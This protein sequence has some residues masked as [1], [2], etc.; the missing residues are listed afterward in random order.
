MSFQNALGHVFFSAAVSA[1]QSS[2]VSSSRQAMCSER[3]STGGCLC[4]HLFSCLFVR[5]RRSA[6]E[7][8]RH[9]FARATGMVQLKGVISQNALMM[10]EMPELTG[11]R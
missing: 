11:L 2:L 5:S 4:P 7:L 6:A 10:A 8:T 9:H 1:G 3:A